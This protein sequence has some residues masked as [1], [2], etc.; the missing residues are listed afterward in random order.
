MIG[1]HFTNTVCFVI[2]GLD[3]IQKVLGSILTVVTRFKILKKIV[4]VMTTSHLKTGVEP[5]PETSYQM[6]LKTMDN[7]QREISIGT[8]NQPTS[9]TFKHSE[10][11]SHLTIH[12]DSGAHTGSCPADSGGCLP[13]LK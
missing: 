9:Q 11:S 1:F 5:T 6:C 13:P 7:V 10:V 8:V 3:C 2:C 12:S 4:C